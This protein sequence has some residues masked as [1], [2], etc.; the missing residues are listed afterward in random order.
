MTDDEKRGKLKIESEGRGRFKTFFWTVI[1]IAFILLLAGFA[2]SRTESF[3]KMVVDHYSEQLGMRVIISEARIDLPYTVVVEGLVAT[4]EVGGIAGLTVERLKL[5]LYKFWDVGLVV[6]GADLRLQRMAAGGWEPMRMAKIGDVSKESQ[7]TQLT[8]KLSK[9]RWLE[10]SDCA[11]TWYAGDG[12]SVERS[13]SVGSF[14]M[15]AD[16]VQGHALLYYRL[17]ALETTPGRSEARSLVREWF[18]TEN[19]DYV[20][21][22]DAQNAEAAVDVSRVSEEGGS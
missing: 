15:H 13:V 18:A 12:E 16:T 1:I 3:H 22:L 5:P 2:V 11:V 19:N 9:R 4:T 17:R 6:E 10:L 14:S 7:I 21:L 8:K 20:S